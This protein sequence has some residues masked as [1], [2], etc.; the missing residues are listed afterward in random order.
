MSPLIKIEKL[1]KTYAAGSIQVAAL[2]DVC[3]EIN[4]GEFVAVMGPSGSGKS[5]LM[6]LLGC[7]D[8][9]SGGS[10]LLDG[11]EL[12]GLNEDRLAKVR[13]R[14]IGFVFQSYNLI[15]KLTAQQNVEA[16]LIYRRVSRSKRKVLAA[17]ALKAVGLEDRG[18]HRPGEL[19]GG[20]QQR[21]AIARALVTEPRILLAD[22]PTGN[23]DSKSGQEVMALFQDLNRSGH[24]I[25]V[26]THSEEI[27]KQCRRVVRMRDGY[28]IDDA[29]VDRPTAASDGLEDAQVEEGVSLA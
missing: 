1:C 18:H 6:N 13:N 23:L 28:I 8:I 10:Y 24:T 3:M 15:A 9:P 26:V 2:I 20:Q 16:P 4:E 19:S 17:A 5:T 11:K 27:A 21:V 12:I 14:E 22:E 7:L 29:P 25:I